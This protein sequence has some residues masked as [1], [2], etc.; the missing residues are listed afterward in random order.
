MARLSIGPVQAPTACR[1]DDRLHRRSER[2]ADRTDEEERHADGERL[3]APDAVADRSPDKLCDGKTDEETRDRQGDPAA[4][5][6][7]HLR[8]RRQVD[9]R[10]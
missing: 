6:H 2:A 5:L 4:K 1:I 8:H 9:V 3:Q 10:R 7:L